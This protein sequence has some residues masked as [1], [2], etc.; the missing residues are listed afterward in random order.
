MLKFDFFICIIQR[1]VSHLVDEDADQ[2]VIRLVECSDATNLV[3]TLTERVKALEEQAQFAAQKEQAFRS[4][5]QMVRE[6]MGIPTMTADRFVV[7]FKKR[8]YDL[9]SIQ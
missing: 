6:E 7:E 2:V 5:L 4:I 3:N 8:I 1:M 9:K